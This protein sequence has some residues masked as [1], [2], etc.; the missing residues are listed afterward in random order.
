MVLAE[1]LLTLVLS[2]QYQVIQLASSLRV[3]MV[4]QALQKDHLA[5]QE[6]NLIRLQSQVVI[7]L[8]S[9]DQAA[10]MA[11]LSHLDGH[12]KHA[13]QMSM[14]MNNIHVEVL[15]CQVFLTQSVI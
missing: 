15:E 11:L 10:P 4:N 8:Q 3:K 6:G 1:L 5:D 13:L 2:N 7:H 12:Q 14:H 9:E